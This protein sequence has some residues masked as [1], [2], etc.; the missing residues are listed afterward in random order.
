MRSLPPRVFGAPLPTLK[1]SPPLDG[2]DHPQYSPPR[3]DPFIR[4]RIMEE[5]LSSIIVLCRRGLSLFS[6]KRPFSGFALLGFLQDVVHMQIFPKHPFI[7]YASI[8]FRH[9][10]HLQH[11]A[12][13]HALPKLQYAKTAFLSYVQSPPHSHPQP[14]DSTPCRFLAGFLSW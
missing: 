11:A 6:R 14:S 3:I 2:T 9:V 13:G 8:R 5:N 1:A 7:A 4:N 10:R 12:A